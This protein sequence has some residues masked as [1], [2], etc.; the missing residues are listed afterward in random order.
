MNLSALWT[1]NGV[2]RLPYSGMPFLVHA[3]GWFWLAGQLKE[4]LSL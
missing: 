4:T 3:L 2:S 1:D